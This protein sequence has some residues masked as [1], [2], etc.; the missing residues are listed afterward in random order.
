MRV[1]SGTMKRESRGFAVTEV[2]YLK[3][4]GF[5]GKMQQECYATTASNQAAGLWWFYA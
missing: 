2:L 5:P 3:R 1:A 4:Y